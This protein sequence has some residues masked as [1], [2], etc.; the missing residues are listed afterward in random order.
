MTEGDVLMWPP[1]IKRTLLLFHDYL[2][3]VDSR[4]PS[5]ADVFAEESLTK[6][7]LCC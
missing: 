3:R 5:I 4:R 1:D 2:L 6:M 7:P